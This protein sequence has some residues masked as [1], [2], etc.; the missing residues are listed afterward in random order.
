MNKVFIML[1]FSLLCG[2]ASAQT[3]EDIYKEGKALYDSKKYKDAVPKFQTSANQGYKK[4]QYYLGRCY[5]KGH[6]VEEDDELAVLWY[7][8]AAAQ[9]HPCTKWDDAIK[10]GRGLKKI[11]TRHSSFSKNPLFRAMPTLNLNLVSA[12]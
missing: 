1:V 11:S 6:G 2:F 3:A 10:K 12:T 5:D 4:A 7:S 9:N 8:K